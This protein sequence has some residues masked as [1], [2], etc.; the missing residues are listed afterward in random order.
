MESEYSKKS[1]EGLQKATEFL[2]KIWWF[3][4]FL[5][6]APLASGFTGYWLFSYIP[7]EFVFIELSLTVITYMF[8]LLFFYKAFDKYRK[9]PFFLNKENNLTARINIIFLISIFSFI[10][11][12]IFTLLSGGNESFAMLPLIS[13]A[14][15]YNIVYYYYRYQPIGFFNKEEGEFKH[16][17]NFQSMVKQPYNF[18]IFINYIAHLIF[19]SLTFFTDLSWF[20]A[21]ITNLV[22]YLITFMTT[23]NFS[24]EINDSIE[25]NKPILK[26]LTKFKQ[27][28][29]ISITSLFF[30]LLI[31]MPFVIIFFSGIQYTSLELMNWSFLSIIFVLIYFK[32]LFYI[33]YYYNSLLDI[34]KDSTKSDDSEEEIPSQGIKYQKYNS[35]LSGVLIGSITFFCFL[36]RTY[37]VVLVILPFFFIFAYYE[38]KAKMCPKK[39]TKYILLVN[40][41]S[42]LIAISFG[43]FSSVFFLNIQFIIFLMS[44]YFILQILV[45]SEYFVKENII[46]IQNFLAIASFTIIAYSLFGYTTF[47]TLI[48]FE[49]AL[50]TSN[51]LIIFIS[52]IL[53][54]GILVST[55]SLVSFYI[56]YARLFSIKR[57]KLFRMSVF[58]QIFLIELF[59]FILV[60]LRF[61]VLF[62]GITAMKLL[63]LSSLLFPLI[64]ILFIF[65]NY[66]LGIFS[67]KNFLRLTYVFLWFLIADIFLVIFLYSLN[68]F[69]IL[70]LDFLFLSILT[71][72]N[73]KFGLQ[74][75]K[76]KD[77]SFKRYTGINHYILTLELYILFF[78]SFSSI[79][80]INL[81]LYDKLVLSSYLSLLVITI[82]INLLWRNNVIFSGS[83]VFK[84]NLIFLIFSAGLG[85]YYSFLYTVNTFYVFLIPFLCLFSILFF[86]IYY[87]Q[88]MKRYEHLTG[89]ILVIDCIFITIFLTMIPAIVSL[90]LFFRLGEVVDVISILNYSIYIAFSLLILIYY[91]VKHYGLG[92]KY[93]RRILKSQVL[94]EILLTGTTVFYYFFILLPGMIYR[95]LLPFIAASIFFYLPILFSYKKKLFN[96]NLVKNTIF[97]NSL[98]LSGFIVLI[99]TIVGLEL[100]RV[101]FFIITTITLILLFLILNF[102][103]FICMKF[104]IFEKI[105][106]HLKL[107]EI[108]TWFSFSLFSAFWIF[109]YLLNELSYSLTIFIFFVLNFYTLRLI[110]NYSKELKISK[111]LRESILYGFVFS[112]SFLIVSLIL[113]TDILN[114]LPFGLIPLNI[115]WYLGLFFLFN[116]LLIRSKLI[117]LEFKSLRNWL[118]LILWFSFKIFIC[119]FISLVVPLSIITQIIIF[120]LFFSILTPISLTYFKNLKIISDRTQ[121]FTKKVFLGVFII[122]SLSL[123]LDIFN[124]LTRNISSF[125]VFN[126]L[127]L[128]VIITNLILFFYFCFLRYN[129]VI[130]NYTITQLIKFY[131]SSFLLLTSQFFMLTIV[132]ILFSFFILILILSCR[133]MINVVRFFIYLL[134]GYVL[135]IAITTVPFGAFI[136]MNTLDLTLLEYYT[137]I[138]LTAISIVLLF[139]IWLN[140][141]RNNIFEKFTLYTTFSLLSFSLLFSYTIIPL[142]YNITISLFL[143][144]FFMGIYFYRLKNVMYKWFIKP[145]VLL[146]VFDLISFI[147]YFLLFNNPPYIGLNPLLTFTLTSGITG[148]V[149]VLLFN[150]SPANFR[151]KSF[152]FVLFAIIFCIP[153]F[154]YFFIITSF[155]IPF[156]DPIPIIFSINVGVFLF[157]LCI[158]I[159]QWRISWEIWKSGWYV[160]NIL[161]FVNF[162]IIYKSLSGVD[163]LESLNLFGAF[164]F[165][166]SSILSIIICSLFFLPVIY[167]KIK[168][169]F[170][171]LVF[172]VWGESLFLLYWISHNL[173]SDVLLLNLLFVL[174]AVLLFMPIIIGLKYW[175]IVSV[176]WMVL[177]IINASFLLFYLVSIGISLDVTISIDILVIGLLMIIYS[178]FPNVRS[179]GIILII[180]YFIVLTGIFITVYFILFS[181]IQD[182][183]FTIN[184][185]LIVVG[186]SLFS[187]KSVKLSHRIIDVSLSWILIVNLAWLTFNTF[188]RLHPQFVMFA[189]FFALTVF[190]CTYFI[191]NKYKLKFRINRIIPLFI[192]AVGTSSSITSL[193]SVF[194]GA[195]PYILISIFS[196]I[197]LIFLYFILIDYRY[198]LWSFIPVPFALP[199]FELLLL[200]EVLRSV[201]FLAFLTF[202]IIYI[203][204]FQV[205]FNAFKNYTRE[206]SKETKNSMMKIFQDKNQIKL[207]NFTSFIL[208]SLFISLLISTLIPVLQDQF[209]FSQFIFIY[210]FLDF[211]I[212]WPVFILFGLKYIEKSDI[213]LK[214]GE[215]KYIEKSDNHL[216]NGGLLPFFNKISFVIYLLIPTALAINFSLYLIFLSIATPIIIY[217]FILILSGVIF[218]ESYIIDM[219]YL[220]YLFESSG[221]RLTFWS[222]FIFSNALSLF[223]FLYHLNFFLL[224]SM[225]ALINQISLS[226]LA[227]LNIPKEKIAIGRLILYYLLFVSGSFYISSLISNGIIMLIEG[228]SGIPYYLMLF[229]NSFLLLFILSYFLIKFDVKL[230]SSIEI[231]LLMIFQ[232]LFAINMIFIFSL[233]NILN[234]FSI[235]LVILIETCF[236]F[237]TVR[238]INTLFY[239]AKKPEFLTRT[240]SLLIIV[241]YLETSLLFY[242][243]MIAFTGIIE[244]ILVSQLIFFALT[245]LDIYSIKKIKRGYA[246]LIHTLSYFVISLLIMLILNAFVAQFQILLSVEVLLFIL[247]QFYTI[248][249]FFI[250]L[251]QLYPNKKELI[252]KR[253]RYSTRILG[254]GFYINLF[255][256]LLQALT[257][258]SVDPQLMLLVLSLMVHVL[259]IIDTYVM[260]FIGKVSNYLNVLSWLFIM[261]FTTIYLI[262]VY[263]IY[264]F[265][266]LVTSVPLI[267][268][269]L[270]IE[271][272]YLFKLLSFSK[273]V[274]SNK[275]KI[276]KILIF[277]LYLDFITWPVYNATVNLF[278]SL[279][280]VLASIGILFILTFIDEYIGVFNE[281]QRNN[282]KK[283]S[284][285][286]IGIFV[287]FDIYLLL[288]FIPHLNVLLKLSEALFIFV[289]FL[290][291]VI[292][293]FKEHSLLAFIFWAATFSL[294]SS[295][296][297]HVSLSWE[298]GVTILV[299]TF[300]IY[301]FVF[302]MEELR[303]LF[304]KF[305]DI[306][307]KTFQKI[308]SL[309]ISALETIYSFVKIHFKVIWTIISIFLGIFF[310]IVLSDIILG[311]LNPIHSTLLALAIFGLLYLIIPYAQTSD[312]DIIFKRRILRLSIGWGS[313]IG[314]LFI[315]ITPEWYI[316]TGFISTAVVGTIIL[317]FLGRKEEREK[318]SVKWRFYT[319]LSL[320]ILLI[321]FGVLFFIQ[322]TTIPI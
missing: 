39:Y 139:S 51:P 117:E 184:I 91:I 305:I 182:V 34:D 128:T 218:F 102:L 37:W 8:A 177:V 38:Q 25:E 188:S 11:T 236:S 295:I 29:V 237:Q 270:V 114:F 180:S 254:V 130:E 70:S 232:S 50:F 121:I 15:L 294:L 208:N 17:T 299:I 176:F 28:F 134:L 296:I 215:I 142:I 166:G 289:I 321:L 315:V 116:L 198:F 302:L 92:D 64:F 154:L 30:I 201:W 307:T 113:I 245:L 253:R 234:V 227:Y 23:R 322:L 56:L 1:E 275:K 36:V 231:V 88:R 249:S 60:N 222:F 84:I 214:R 148:F 40:F 255:L 155:S 278:Y 199:L 61:F 124:V 145:C 187:S 73:L 172:I 256:L 58:A 69:F 98:L 78:F 87:I 53:L 192:V 90:D 312:P 146:A 99:P 43:L 204:L 68:N 280:L 65:A 238:Y 167:T 108:L 147:S 156:T 140:Y 67:R 257:I 264:F 4:F 131:L 279:N 268:F 77:S 74:L 152:Y 320:F 243:L 5:V 193:F 19:L 161:P 196:G 85:F 103:D 52:N 89:K 304:N 230:K 247:M 300:A 171:K 93:Q 310:G 288:G 49:L 71:Q 207:V 317:V 83:I 31:Q 213:H 191:F 122:S 132:P 143:F 269:I 118:E 105:I 226:F 297:Y 206:D 221:R 217:S 44:F 137:Q 239:E 219:R 168:K 46:V 228:L 24:S 96:Q 80:L 286:T 179:I 12:P 175:K 129:S 101:D 63:I 159:Y 203:T 153:T 144:L 170:L 211:L 225:I 45:K 290:G 183:I 126:F 220:G 136:Y 260:K 185:S 194:L 308:K 18:I 186:F 150:K 212:I 216:K 10:G 112:S 100:L 120:M 277:I 62:E 282:I 14:V 165:T 26:N 86:P 263:N 125:N 258:F 178:F 273:Y 252:D 57:S 32:M 281:K 287:S 242:G 163:V 94:I 291:I 319:L 314:L 27:R 298:I 75:E 283:I 41:A 181:S 6:V 271:T 309:I 200:I 13:F 35:I 251:L 223:F 109:P 169:Y 55:V 292:K 119:L 248:Y 111:Y 316:F 303:E 190:G 274:I 20:F 135:F 79:L 235:I 205:I 127:P 95:F 259:M 48:I 164:E 3:T 265:T 2:Q 224:L 82:F 66:L 202:S 229:Q 157:Y 47:E 160:W 72:I 272:Y 318:I 81:G 267:I 162:I 110:S 115:V 133:S 33:N 138:Y 149:F 22:F 261:A 244:S 141:K 266:I 106:K 174:F 210:Q 209:L 262:W 54:H 241:L 246:Q 285:L 21:L 284:F 151:R 7:G 97:V 16:V 250:S 293:P 158:G 233:F 59:I 9:K 301:P 195:S 189:F 123:F 306:L 197:F 42:I 313:V 104:K 240:F 76:I 276:R 107:L 173:F 311:L